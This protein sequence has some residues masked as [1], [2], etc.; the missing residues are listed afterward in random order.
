MLNRCF[1]PAAALLG[2]G[3]SAFAG[4][5]PSLLFLEPVVAGDTSTFATG[6]SA[7]GSVV[8]GTS[9]HFTGFQE[10]AVR[11]I[12]GVPELIP[13]QGA[14]S[15][16]VAHGCSADG[17]VVVG[18]M[19]HPIGPGGSEAIYRWTPSQGAQI[20]FGAGWV[21]GISGDGH[22][23]ITVNSALQPA[24]HID[25]GGAIPL[26]LGAGGVRGYASSVSHDGSVIVGQRVG[27]T[28]HAVYWPSFATAIT[29]AVTPPSRAEAV[30]PDGTIIV[31]HSN[32]TGA[33]RSDHGVISP[34][35]L[36][37]AAEFSGVSNDG[38]AVGFYGPQ[39]SP[40]G[41]LWT[42]QGGFQDLDVLAAS[43]GLNLQGYTLG[44]VHAIS[45]DGSTIVGWAWGPTEAR[46]FVLVI[47]APGTCVVVGV[48]ALAVGRRRR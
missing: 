16:M 28:Q 36:P 15:R 13:V 19:R 38:T 7:D 22:T 14:Y 4:P 24:R 44:E 12:N 27:A 17:S 31:G 18:R 48:V 41:F 23:T 42:E 35:S 47:P 43:W 11:W 29:M 46:G 39:F 34:I 26:P 3:S 37:V 20:L 33:F 6:V 25:N 2:F 40:E 21:Y 8:V 5:I 9:F 1:A 45:A 10:R 30:S 32:V